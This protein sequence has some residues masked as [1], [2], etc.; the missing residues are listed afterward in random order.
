[1]DRTRAGWLGLLLAAILLGAAWIYY[2]RAPLGAGYDPAH[3]A[4]APQPGFLAPDFTLDT[5]DGGTITL[6]D[7]RGAPVVVNFWATWCPPC[8]AEMP[9]FE[10]VSRHY[11][12][13]VA[14]LGVDQGEP[15]ELVAQF[16][17]ELNITYPLPLDSDSRVSRQYQVRSLPTT[18]FIDD[19]G[20]VRDIHIG[21]ISQAVLEEK[22]ERLL[23]RQR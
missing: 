4:S 8:R 17:A 5:P 23:S 12:G 19:R 3:L 15:A 21:L 16:A 2:S 7:Y 1:M 9:F 14:I 6:S 13:R 22:I 10:N 11:E 20:I 18:F